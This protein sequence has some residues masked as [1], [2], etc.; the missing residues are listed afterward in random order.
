MQTVAERREV[1]M[2]PYAEKFGRV[3]ERF[4]DVD[5]QFKRVDQR[6]VEVKEEIREVKGEVRDVKG[7]VGALRRAME[8]LHAGIHQATLA[9]WIGSAG[10]V[11][12]ILVKG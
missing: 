3:D 6:F 1:P 5:R 9:L 12:A 10:I 2:E 7:E 8:T 4:D 11:V